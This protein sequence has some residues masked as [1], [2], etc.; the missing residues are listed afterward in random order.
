MSHRSCSAE[1]YH[2][3]PEVDDSED[4][5][6]LF[7]ESAQMITDHYHKMF[8]SETTRTEIELVLRKL[9][10]SGFI[11][12][13]WSYGTHMYWRPKIKGTQVTKFWITVVIFAAILSY[14]VGALIASYRSH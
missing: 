11:K 6:Y 10:E 4:R 8:E 7:G 2:C 14:I 3:V 9:V 5:S 12:T 13:Q 1:V